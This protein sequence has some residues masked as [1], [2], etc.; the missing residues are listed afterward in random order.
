MGYH[1]DFELE[2]DVPELTGKVLLITGGEFSPLQIELP[3]Y[4]ESQGAESGQF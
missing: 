1:I 4:A 3:Q 2:R